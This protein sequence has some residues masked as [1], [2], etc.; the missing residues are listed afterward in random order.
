MFEHYP[1]APGTEIDAGRIDPALLQGRIIAIIGYGTMGRAQALNLVRSG[2][3]V[4][5]GSRE[6]SATG[7]R[8]RAEGLKVMTVAAAVAVA[9]VV[10]LMLPDEAMATVYTAAV[11]PHLRP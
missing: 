2:C 11:A 7:A 8:A 3:E 6:G 9:D 10:M 4:V 5:V 1:P